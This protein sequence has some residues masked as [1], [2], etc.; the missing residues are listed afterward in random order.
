LV[1][2]SIIT[3][4]VFAG[5]HFL[6][7]EKCNPK[8]SGYKFKLTIKLN[9]HKIRHITKYIVKLNCLNHLEIPFLVWIN[10]STFYP[11]VNKRKKLKEINN[12]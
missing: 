7:E 4:V 9:N 12:I 8:F 5:F 11:D 6:I 3:V 1:F 10:H 2:S